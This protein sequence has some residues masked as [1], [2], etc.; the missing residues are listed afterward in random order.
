VRCK[1]I[2]V[3]KMTIQRRAGISE[4]VASGVRAIP[5]LVRKCINVHN[6]LLFIREEERK[7]YF[8]FLTTHFL[9]FHEVFLAEVDGDGAAEDDESHAGEGE[10][11]GNLVPNQ[12]VSKSA[13]GNTITY[14]TDPWGTRIEIVQ[15]APL[16]PQ[17]Q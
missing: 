8:N 7:T 15:R 3:K 2:V 1:V 14:I 16:G 13:A 6:P 4:G 11:V 5:I 17:V 10:S 12:P 9:L